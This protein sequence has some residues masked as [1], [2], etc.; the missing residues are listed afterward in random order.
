MVVRNLLA[1]IPFTEFIIERVSD[2]GDARNAVLSGEFDVCLL[3][4]R[5]SECKGLELLEE[6]AS[7]G[8]VLPMVFLTGD[9][10]RDTELEVMR[11]GAAD[12]LPKGEL[13]ATFLERS[14]RHAVERQRKT[15]TLLK[16]KR[17]I[18][19]LS[20]CNHAVI[21]IEDEAELLGA[22]C[23]IVV[24]V[25]GYRMAWVGYAEED[26]EK[27]VTPA[28]WYGY[29]NGYLQTANITWEDVERGRGPTGT[30][31]RTGTPSIIR[32]ADTQAEFAPWKAEALRRG[33][34]SVIGLPLFLNAR[35]LGALTIYSSEQDA[36]DTEEVEFLTK[37]AGN[38]S[39]GLGVLRLREALI[40]AE[41][42]LKETNFDLE[43]RVEERT[44]E[45]VKV[46][47]ELREEAEERKRAEA[48]LK[49]SQQQ[50]AHIIDFLP[51]ATFVIDIEGKIIAWNRAME[52]MLGVEAADV[53]GKGDHE[54]ALQFY[55]ERRLTLI[56]LVLERNEEI[57]KKYCILERKDAVL[58]AETYLTDFKGR[59]AY[60]FCTASVLY[61]SMG[62]ITGSIESIRDIT[63][64]KLMEKAASEAQAKYRDIFENSVTGIFQTLPDGRALR[65]NASIASMFGYESTDELINSVSNA[66]CVYVRP[67]H[68][69]EMLH[70]I[71]DRGWV[72]EFETEFFRKDKSIIWVSLDIRAVRDSTGEIAYLEGTIRN[73]TDGKL[74]RT[75]LM[76]AQKMEALGT[77]AGGIAHDFNNIL[78]PIIGYTELSLT[79]VP[80]DANLHHNMS[81][82]LLSAYRAKDL[83]SQI[84][85]FS[86]KTKK[87]RE[88]VQVSLVIKEALKLIRSSLPST[89]LLHQAIS[90]DATDS[91]VL[92]DPIQ[93]HQ[94]LMNLCTNAA[95]AMQDKGGTLAVTLENV[96]IGDSTAG[97]VMELVP[98]SYL[99]LSVADTGI[100][101]DEAVKRRIFEPYF[102][103]KGPNEGTGLG[104]SVIYGIV[105]DLSGSISVSGSPG[106]GTTFDVYFPR[107]GKSPSPAI[108]LSK[109]L[110]TGRG[111]VLVVDDEKSIVD[112]I[113]KMLETLGY[114]AV[115]R[116]SSPDALDAFRAGPESFDLVITDMTM[117]H[118][119]GLDLAKA[120]LMIR[121]HTAIILCTGFS[122]TVDE[123]KLELLGIKRLLMKPVS[124][125]E[126]AITV[127]ELLESAR[128]PSSI[129]SH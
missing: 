47:A 89:I 106:Q 8:T 48:A 13:N 124:M 9:L 76:Q 83:V 10:N 65:V 114:E 84:L 102:T 69:S 37:L 44:A 19:A 129:S 12:C 115:P 74:L 40:Q 41:E 87:E 49:E 38:L 70:L 3:N 99:R 107:T 6:T 22:I 17:V 67:E 35:R 29:E 128:P 127:N 18:Q 117:P 4:Y 5:L 120:V 57:E 63:D 45:L 36:F 43:T 56:D 90:R 33:Y 20:E 39:Y 68:R 75:Q 108:E 78:A 80:V 103:T 50:L 109:R 1:E 34:A 121:P 64:R 118:M 110:P 7:R 82:V 94:V 123:N 122:D 85:T 112:M 73:I 79:S 96:E 61:D 101:M 105:K 77:L 86:R 23:H 28:A 2:Y 98:G 88:L 11:R 52:E 25:G 92:A 66:Q 71:E 51:D 26:P 53:L 32:F 126:L 24:D 125:R 15:E 55:G 14:I 54:Y 59:E 91:A 111:R 113:K 46:N 95:H 21:H 81:H 72:Q 58:S 31:I 62:N 116:Y 104:L 97:M 93:I 27:T 30:C 60:L 119:T 16:S 42:E 100:G